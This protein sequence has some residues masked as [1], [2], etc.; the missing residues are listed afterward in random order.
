MYRLCRFAVW[1]LATAPFWADASGYSDL[2]VFGDSLSDV[3]NTQA[4]TSST[5]FFVY[6]GSHYYQ[7][8]FSNG[9]VY[10]ELLS[11]QLG[12]GTLSRSS[13][14][15]DNF[16][17]GGA[18]TTGTSGISGAFINDV[19]EQ[20][21][22]YTT[23]RT[24]N[25]DALYIMWA[26]ANDLFDGQL[27]MSIPV[28]NIASDIEQLYGDGARQFLVMNLPKLGTTPA[29]N[30]TEASRTDWNNRT[31]LFNT[32][33]ASGLDAMESSLA[34]IS[35]KRFDIEALFDEVLASP[36]D[37]GLTNVT[38]PAAPGLEPGT[39]FYD[40]GNIV[41]NPENYLFWD[42]VHPTATMHAHLANAVY[43]F[44]TAPELLPG[45]FNGD[46]LVNLA[47]YTVWRGALGA[48][49]DALINNSGNQI[50]GV[51]AGDYVVWKESFGQLLAM[52]TAD[53]SRV[54]EPRSRF[55]VLAAAILLSSVQRRTR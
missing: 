49:D 35:I 2:F 15:G 8:R 18:K 43:E 3:G 6:P 24:G 1:F 9:P 46:G 25:P 40:D 31:L 34:Q 11:L 14:G 16:A 12:L 13:A 23:T 36:G 32:A 50:P 52:A 54:P 38:S 47:D 29:Y 5:I 7:G 39:F 26:G 42:T 48:A 55:L 20:V 22:D 21:D 4:A 37:Y 27:D 30:G 17:Y 10:S 51:D 44:L 28:G 41:A 53:A 19:G 33:L 45:D